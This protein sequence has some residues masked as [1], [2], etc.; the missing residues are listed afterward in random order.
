[1]DGFD[2]L[3]VGAGAGAGALLQRQQNRHG[4]SSGSGRRRRASFLLFV[5]LPTLVATVYYGLFAA[6]QYVS[7]A[8][9]VV[10]GQ[11]NQSPGMLSSLLAVGGG[12]SASEDTYAVQNYIM[13]RDAAQEMSRQEDLRAVFDRSEADPLSR[14]PGFFSSDTFES[15]FRFYQKH[16]IAELDSTTSIS[17][18]TVRTFRAQDS[19][20]IAVAELKAAEQLINRMNDRQRENTISASVHEVSLAENHLRAISAQMAEYRNR[21]ALLDPLKQ[22]EPMLKA[23]TDL[24][25]MVTSTQ[26]QLA[27]LEVST[28]DSPMITVYKR[29]MSA[30]LAQI[31]H[32]NGGI[33]GSDTSLVP[34]IM[35]YEDLTVQR[36]LAEKEL[37]VAATAMQTAKT[38]ADRQLM[39][40]DEISQP[41]RPDYASYPRSVVSILVVFASFLGLYLMARLLIN[42]AREHQLV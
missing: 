8:Q 3:G 31:A 23:I 7:Q 17:T 22:S 19:Q 40:L 12:S 10:R 26:V 5:I 18:L 15:F 1:M 14:F 20:R 41:N 36:E 32:A 35:A 28:P 21:E 25:A 39:Y 38:Q 4:F 24:Q 11:G 30:L 6:P 42:G 2:S 9:F 33:T 37:V 27:Q 34:K 29:R 16:I 13:S